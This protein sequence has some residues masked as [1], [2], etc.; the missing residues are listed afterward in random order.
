MA[1]LILKQR[2][3][4]LVHSHKIIEIDFILSNDIKQK[5]VKKKKNV[6][7]KCHFHKGEKKKMQVTS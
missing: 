1:L 6:K 5:I 3:F 7:K 4:I 2:I